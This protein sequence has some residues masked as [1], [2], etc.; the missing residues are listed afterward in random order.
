MALVNR[1]NGVATPGAFYGY[2]PLVIK[3]AA[4]AGFGANSVSNGVITD[5]GYEKAVR[6]IQQFG[7]VVWLGA[8]SA[9]AFTC[10]VDGPTFNNGAGLPGGVGG[11]YGALRDAMA[12]ATGVAVANVT[13]TTS[14]AL[15]GDGTFTFV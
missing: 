9:N 1:F 12:A 7:S 11:S 6:A 2:S 5:G 3:V 4:T 8:Q 13:V 14:S 10:I 15:N